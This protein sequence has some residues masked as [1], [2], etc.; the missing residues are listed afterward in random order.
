[1]LNADLYLHDLTAAL[2]AAFGD[3]LAYV[4]LQ[5]S[6]LR[7]DANEDS[8]ID[9]TVLI[10]ALTK[11]DLDRYRVILDALGHADK[12][13]GFLCGV[14]DFSRWN[15]LEIARL[16]RDTRD[17]YGQLSDFVPLYSM[18]DH[19]KFVSMSL[20]SLYH[21]L[22]HRYVH[23]DAEKNRRKLASHRKELFFLLQDLTYLR[24]GTFPLK[25]ETLL[26]MLDA[27]SRTVYRIITEEAVTPEYAFDA[28][29]ETVLLWLQK[30]MCDIS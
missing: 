15:P 17:Y 12:S 7:E 29:F 24:T 26:Q 6:Y 20:G 16:L 27:E 14:E 9:V 23:A 11:D 21:A 5:G 3:R 30:T 18:E 8:D 10:R 13:C 1:M 28:A 25:R 22:C 2:K 4:G 19:K